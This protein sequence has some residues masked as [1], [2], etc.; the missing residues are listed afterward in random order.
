MTLGFVQ[1]GIGRK[2]IVALALAA[3]AVLAVTLV[4]NYLA[5]R[6]NW[7]EQTDARSM[8]SV[9]H[10]AKRLD[11]LLTRI[12]MIPRTTATRQKLFGTSP[13]PAMLDYLRELLPQLPPEEAYGIYIAYEA[14]AAN[15]PGAM[16]WMDR[17]DHPNPTLVKYDYHDASQEWYNGPKSSKS[18][19]IT[20]PYFDAG[21]SNIAMVSVTYPCVSEDGV[22]IGTA[23]IDLSLGLIRDIV[24]QIEFDVNLANARLLDPV[25]TSSNDA[26]NGMDE[27]AYLISRSGFV[28]SHPD[29][30]LMLNEKT[31]G[32]NAA[33][34]I[35]GKKT[36]GT[37]SGMD[38]VTIDGD[39]RRIYWTTSPLSGWKLI[40][41]VSNAKVMGPVVRMTMQSIAISAVGLF[42][43]LG[44]IGWI[45]SQWAK[46]IRELS[47]QARLLSQG[48]IATERLL[49]LVRR[50]D[51]LGDLAKN[52]SEMSREIH[53][54]EKELRSLNENLTHLVHE[55]TA[56]LERAVVDA[57]TAKEQAIE[58][59]RTKSAFLA[60][61]S[62][63]LRTPMNAIIGY[64]E[65]LIEEVE[66]AE[67]GQMVE[68]LAKIHAAG[69]HLL[70]LINDI[71][72]LS[73]IEAGRMTVYCETFSVSS[74]IKEITDTIQPLIKK[75][76]NQLVVQA[77][78]NLGVMN[79]DLTKLRQLLF[80][81]LSNASKFTEKGTITLDVVRESDRIR[82]VV[83]D[84]GIGMTEAQ[85]DKLFQPFTQA[86][87]STTRKYGGTGLGLTISRRFCEMLGGSIDVKS[88][89]GQ[90]SQFIVTLPTTAPREKVA[91]IRDSIRDLDELGG[92]LE[93]IKLDAA[94]AGKRTIVVVD[95]DPAVCEL[96]DRFLTKEGFSVKTIKNAK[97][98]LD[99]IRKQPPFAVTCDLMMPGMDGWSFLQAVKEDP[100]I[101]D[102]PVIMI[103][104]S[105]NRELGI[106]LG[107]VEFLSKPVDWNDLSRVLERLRSQSRASSNAWNAN[108]LLLVE[109]DLATSE[110]TSKLL[111]SHG[112][113]VHVASNGKAALQELETF[114][115]AVILLDLMMPEMDGF[116]FLTEYHRRPNAEQIPIIVLT[117]MDLDEQQRA[118]LASQTVEI[119]KKG[120][121]N[122]ETILD[123]L[124]KH[125]HSLKPTQD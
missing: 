29:S 46:P 33:D 66:D 91:G 76:Q 38:L 63:E 79:S 51:E 53:D 31:R 61:M 78:G 116:Q 101:C 85:I 103:S 105:P 95:D 100:A 21:G 34:L 108:A 6:R 37:E 47:E 94:N 17:K 93:G 83:S 50:G 117:A 41:N 43:L 115:P 28:V 97:D 15:A 27:Y 90:G 64:S 40:Y 74:T 99:F 80:N 69:K 26:S 106:A 112:W 62:H 44:L 65:M 32:T 96:M 14:M 5:S 10:A 8:A 98:A 111:E 81:L 67:D 56:D 119:L 39:L 107:A 109:D 7:I 9:Q 45:A 13:D 71:L 54:R 120:S 18:L 2:L 24:D 1:K 19:Y 49:P 23:G 68:D 114:V 102:I 52:F 88:Q 25:K 77:S 70:G 57:E 110:M 59:N 4:L 58:A 60:N 30:K 12:A 73:K 55:R 22:Y 92:V 123:H 3:C 84:T 36:V 124:K 48:E 16:P 87:A 82:F 75:N 113:K 42:S 121:T 118:F 11:D 125:I 86:D 122:S 104:I 89:L 72:D 35:D 20:E